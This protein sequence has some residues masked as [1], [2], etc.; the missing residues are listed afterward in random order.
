MRVVLGTHHLIAQAGADTYLVTVAEQLLALGHD[1]TIHA[2]EQ[3]PMADR[4]RAG[5]L[6]VAAGESQLP[7]AVDAVVAQDEVTALQLADRY[8]TAPRVFV[9]HS[10]LFGIDAPPQVP[11]VV[12]AI[13]VM[14]DRV[15]RHLAAMPVRPEVVRLRQPIDVNRFRPAGTAREQPRKLVAIGNYARGDRRALLASVAAEMGLET[16]FHGGEDP[17]TDQ[18]EAAMAW[19]DIVVGKSRV[20]LEAM[21]CGRAAYVYDFLGADGWVTPERYPALEADAFLGQAT[22]A[23]VERARLL[24]ELA[25]YRPDMGGANRD[26]ALAH[27]RADDHA[28]A[29]VGLLDRLAGGPVAPPPDAPLRALARMAQREWLAESALL[30]ERRRAD[31]LMGRLRNQAERSEQAQELARQ[32]TAAVDEIKAS[33][34]YRLAEA[35]SRPAERL[36]RRPPRG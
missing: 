29:L 16:S 17:P 28:R 22:D 6:P 3:G 14:S 18:P 34:R 12:S 36:R 10:D 9:C 33:R 30:D 35:L 11:D 32:A 31:D 1:V 8:P 4:A 21:A 20:T 13:V 24:R 2:L 19:A 27:H 25:A 15:A 26:L 7:D 23:P 5:G